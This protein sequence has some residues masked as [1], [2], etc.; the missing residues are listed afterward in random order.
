V[1]ESVLD[2]IY[3]AKKKAFALRQKLFSLV[4]S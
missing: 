2:L 4:A 1:E 3:I